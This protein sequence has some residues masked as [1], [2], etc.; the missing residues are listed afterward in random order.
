MSSL[1]KE[2]ASNGMIVYSIGHGDLTGLYCKK[3]EMRAGK[4]LTIGRPFNHVNLDNFNEFAARLGVRQKELD[5]LIS[6]VGVIGSKELGIHSLALEH[7]TLMGH[8]LGGTS[9]I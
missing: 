5:C 2:L 7:L 8:S 3:E 4:L 1:C 6:E 9:S